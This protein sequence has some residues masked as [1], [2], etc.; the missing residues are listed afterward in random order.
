MVFEAYHRNLPHNVQV[1]FHK[2]SHKYATRRENNL[3]VK[4]TRTTLKSMCVTIK[5]VKI[6]NNLENTIKE[7]LHKYQFRKKYKKYLISQYNN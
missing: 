7:S 5:G 4:Y 3:A 6:W 2:S 1:L